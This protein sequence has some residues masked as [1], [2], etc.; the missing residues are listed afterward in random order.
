MS[1]AIGDSVDLAFVDEGYEGERAAKAAADHRITSEVV[2]LPEVR[3]GF[4]L[5]PRRWVV[6]R[7]YAW[8]GRFRR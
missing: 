3:R 7:S 6:E 4:V 1:E 2:K 5:L 8:I